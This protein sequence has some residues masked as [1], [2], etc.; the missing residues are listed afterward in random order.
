MVETSV[1]EWRNSTFDT[2]V[3]C[4]QLSSKLLL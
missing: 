2:I 4:L 3:I 1:N